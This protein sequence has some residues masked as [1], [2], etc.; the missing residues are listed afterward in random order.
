MRK[1]LR[2]LLGFCC[3][4]ILDFAT[5]S[6]HAVGSSPS[7]RDGFASVEFYLLNVR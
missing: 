4:S 7:L 6:G 2:G 3:I 1:L 5:E